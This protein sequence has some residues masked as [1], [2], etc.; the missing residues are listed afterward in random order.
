MKFLKT[1]EKINKTFSNVC[2][3]FFLRKKLFSCQ[4]D[5]CDFSSPNSLCLMLSPLGSSWS[6]FKESWGHFALSFWV[7]LPLVL[8][9]SNLLLENAVLSLLLTGCQDTSRRQRLGFLFL[10]PH[11]L[12]GLLREGMWTRELPAILLLF[13]PAAHH[14]TK[15]E[16]QRKNVTSRGSQKVCCFSIV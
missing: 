4:D 2:F 5:P 9:F 15:T 13:L 1:L 7:S 3:F 6:P 16:R 11:I 10:Q 14:K 12:Q 8:D